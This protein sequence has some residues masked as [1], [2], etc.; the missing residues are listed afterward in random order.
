MRTNRLVTQITAKLL[1]LGLS[2]S[3]TS[4]AFGAEQP[5]SASSS[6]SAIEQLPDSPGTVYTQIAQ[7]STSPADPQ[8]APIAPAVQNQQPPAQPNE[9][10]PPADA[11]P[12]EQQKEIPPAEQPRAPQPQ[13][14]QQPLGTAAAESIATSGVAASRPSG[15]AV[16]PAK[17][18]RTR[19]ILIGVAAL[20][21][22]G[23][24]IG[25][26]YALSSGSP[27]VPPGAR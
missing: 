6:T 25:T 18:R 4:L 9:S 16:A 10:Q 3:C 7:A 19:T 23:V 2:T 27:S 5:S 26:V 14:T 20:L 13:G 8:V 1:V 24:A 12:Q 17:P 21:G 22:A 11:Q 15:E